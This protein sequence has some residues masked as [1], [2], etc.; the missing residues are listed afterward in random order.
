M[1]ETE[2]DN[3]QPSLL[4]ETA[5]LPVLSSGGEAVPAVPGCAA[6]DECAPAALVLQD[7]T[8]VRPDDNQTDIAGK[9]F[10]IRRNRYGVAFWNPNNIAEAI[11]LWN[12]GE[13]AGMI[14]GKLGTTRHAVIGKLFRMGFVGDPT[15]QKPVRSARSPFRRA[16]KFLRVPRIIAPLNPPDTS[17]AIHLLDVSA[18]DRRCRFPLWGDNEQSEFLFC[19]HSVAHDATNYC[20]FHHVLTHSEGTKSERNAASIPTIR[21]NTDAPELVADISAEATAA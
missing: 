19:G 21:I 4:P 9:E 7:T 3:Q 1:S 13:S 5:G 17:K 11:R 15:R 12:D 16:P 8:H 14:G 18:F 20:G 10:R 6:K 2:N